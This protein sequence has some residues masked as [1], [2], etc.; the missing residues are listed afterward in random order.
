[1]PAQG[2][3]PNLEGVLALLLLP[4]QTLLVPSMEFVEGVLT[5]AF[6]L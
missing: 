1:M 5:L 2:F 6:G 4:L 3:S